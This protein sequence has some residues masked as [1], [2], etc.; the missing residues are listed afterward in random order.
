MQGYF[1]LLKGFF[2]SCSF[3]IISDGPLRIPELPH[4]CA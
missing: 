1:S 2:D 4:A 3:K